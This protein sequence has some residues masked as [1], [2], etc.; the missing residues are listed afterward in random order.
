MHDLKL[1]LDDLNG[2]QQKLNKRSGSVSLDALSGLNTKRKQL[3]K[4]YDDLRASQNEASQKIAQIKKE[5]GDASDLL[6]QMQDVS[7]RA[8]GLAQEQT[9]LEDQIK[10]FL[11]TLPNVPDDSVPVGKD[12]TANVEVRRWG[13]PKTFDFKP[14]EHWEIGES[15]GQL[16]FERAAK[17]TGS[18]FVVYRRE[19]ARLERALA[20][21]MLDHLQ[22]NY[23][24]F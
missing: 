23:G 17:L 22:K 20:W 24:Y 1:I 10:S 2:F 7:N 9:E 5:K 21:F 19:L 18:R 8:K 11:A 15:S 12:E 16:D 14:K 13:T 3:Q 6:A 4:E